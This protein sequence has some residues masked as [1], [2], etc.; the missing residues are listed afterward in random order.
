LPRRIRE[1]ARPRERHVGDRD[2]QARRDLAGKVGCHAVRLARRAFASDQ[3]EI[4]QV[5]PGAQNA[6]RGKLGDH[7]L[8]HGQPLRDC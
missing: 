3:Q 1:L 8:G 4:A 2:A 5:D 7:F 6:P